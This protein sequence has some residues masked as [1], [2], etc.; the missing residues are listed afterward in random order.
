MRK[1]SPR[2]KRWNTYL[3][4]SHH[5][6]ARV[7]TFAAMLTEICEDLAEAG[8]NV[9]I[10]AMRAPRCC[11]RRHWRLTFLA[12]RSEPLERQ[13]DGVA[14]C[15]RTRS[16]ARRSRRPVHRRDELRGMPGNPDSMLPTHPDRKSLRPAMLPCYRRYASR[17]RAPEVDRTV[18]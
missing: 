16:K 7:H 11:R 6:R 5:W 14:R 17:P 4:K 1:L 13:E 12:L 10:A 15:R 18:R 2:R 9:E 8:K 3:P